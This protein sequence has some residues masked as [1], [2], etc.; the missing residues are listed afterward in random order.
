MKRKTWLERRLRFVHA[1]EGGDGG[2]GGGG[3]APTGGEPAPA[4]A[5]GAPA[6]AGGNDPAAA[7]RATLPEELRSEASLQNFSDVGALAKSYVSAQGM[8]GADKIVVPRTD[9]EWGNAYAKLGR[10]ETAGDYTLG[11]PDGF[12]PDAESQSSLKELAHGLG[13]NQKQLDGLNGWYWEQVT[14]AMQGAA[15]GE[16][17]AFETSTIELKSMWGEKFDGNMAI[18]NRALKSIAGGKLEGVLEAKGMLNDPVMTEFLAEVGNALLGEDF[19]A[20]VGHGNTS[21]PQELD[22]QITE[23]MAHPA[24]TN[25]N[26]PQH[27]LQVKKV[28]DLYERRYGATAA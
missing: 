8:L 11:V 2:S 4:P 10:P 7:F 25:R 17:H 18:A 27:Q 3:G 28:R 26:D 12:E 5:G 13:L 22:Q 24:Y 23:A 6:P 16:Q 14:A 15:Q 21:S 20:G 19:M 9:E 1:N